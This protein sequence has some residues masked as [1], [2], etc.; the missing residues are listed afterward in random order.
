MF[1]YVDIQKA[2]CV[3]KYI[4]ELNKCECVYIYI[5]V[6]IYEKVEYTVCVC[7]KI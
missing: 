6:C 1:V 3:Y 7:L 2:H 4:L 5:F